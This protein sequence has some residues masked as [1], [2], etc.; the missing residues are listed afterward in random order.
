[1]WVKLVLE[2]VSDEVEEARLQMSEDVELRTSELSD[3]DGDP[4]E[5]LTLAYDN[6]YARAIG[7]YGKKNTTKS[8]SCGGCC[9]EMDPL[10][11]QAP[12]RR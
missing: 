2:D 10:L 9:F 3:A 11:L 5:R 4:E 8:A 7:S 6:V 1:M 12:Y